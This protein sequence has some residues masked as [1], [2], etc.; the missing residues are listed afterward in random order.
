LGDFLPIGRQFSL[1]WAVFWK[2][3]LKVSHIL[4]ALFP[5]LRFCT[6]FTKSVG[7]HIGRFFHKPIRS[8]WLKETDTTPPKCAQL[9][10][11]TIALRIASE[12]LPCYQKLFFSKK[13]L[14][15]LG[16]KLF[17]IFFLK[18]TTLYS[19]WR[20]SISR[21]SLHGGRRRWYPTRPM[22]P[23]AILPSF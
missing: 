22:T 18:A 14:R 1:L 3:C 4:G 5:W 17:S 21:T 11:I 16:H 9:L 10:L 20:D 6:D 23:M 19:I 7:L 13:Q 2:L 15:W 12:I 8:P